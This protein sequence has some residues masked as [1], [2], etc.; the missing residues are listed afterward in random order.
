MT[1]WA[2]IKKLGCFGSITSNVIVR[3]KVTTVNN[4]DS[5][6]LP[7]STYKTLDIVNQVL[8][9]V[10][11]NLGDYFPEVEGMQIKNCGL[12]ELRKSDLA[13]F[14]KAIDFYFFE[15]KLQFLPGNLLEGNPEL[16]RIYFDGN[17]ISSMDPNVLFPVK[18]LQV[19]CFSSN[20]CIDKN[21][22]T[23]AE[24]PALEAALNLNCALPYLLEE[25][26]KCQ[27]KIEILEKNFEKKIDS[28]DGIL[29]AATRQ[30][31]ITEKSLE[32]SPDEIDMR[33]KFNSKE[34]NCKAI[35]FIVENPQTRVD[36]VTD[37]TGNLF[38]HNFEHTEK[39]SIVDQQTLFLPVNLFEKF[40]QLKEV[41]II[42]SGLFHIYRTTFVNLILLKSLTIN[43]NKLRE[44]P[45]N[46]LVAN[47]NLWLLNLEGNNIEIID[48]DSFKNLE[49]LRELN[50]RR[51]LL[52]SISAA[53]FVQLASL[54]ILN[55]ANNKIVF[56]SS[57]LFSNLPQL[58]HIDISCKY[59]IETNI[60]ENK[61]MAK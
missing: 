12:K 36:K 16:L 29:N 13:Q 7:I 6:S 47:V 59:R 48:K 58:S 61:F 27:T 43:E 54:E 55:L 38:D 41:L 50:L 18:K 23:Q 56:V 30:L 35:E 4:Q 42:N 21:A 40:P 51:N 15:N 53:V 2:F 17:K 52:T 44:I 3:E 11:Q 26:K 33:C 9:F 25:K 19:A 32:V 60:F 8:H 5:K 57:G 28:C 34:I 37:E 31:F 1:E 39:L 45:S 46:V 14:P 22:V 10:P 20:I 24:I 49:S